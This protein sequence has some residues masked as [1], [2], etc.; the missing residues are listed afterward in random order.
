M[1]QATAVWHAFL[2]VA[3]RRP[4]GAHKG[5]AG[6]AP[7]QFLLPG[8]QRQGRWKPLFAERTFG[9]TVGCDV[10][11]GTCCSM[12]PSS[13]VEWLGA[14]RSACRDLAGNVLSS[15]AATPSSPRRLSRM[16]N[17]SAFSDVSWSES[18]R[19][20]EK[21]AH[22]LCPIA[23]SAIRV[24]PVAWVP[25]LPNR[26]SAAGTLCPA[27]PPTSVGR[28]EIDDGASTSGLSDVSSAGSPPGTMEDWGEYADRWEHKVDPMSV[29]DHGS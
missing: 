13:G 21:S 5:T 12:G 8:P 23:P 22:L 25:C 18:R 26:Q 16:S 24:T 7:Q 3:C 2:T 29:V 1:R 9:G 19:L 10:C 6:T 4:M 27:G 14:G 17:A 20:R 11:P 15:T 28:N